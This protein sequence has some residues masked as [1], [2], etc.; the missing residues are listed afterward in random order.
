[1]PESEKT[2]EKLISHYR[3]KELKLN[4]DFPE[5]EMLDCRPFEYSKL[6]LSTDQ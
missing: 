1:M 4:N 2:Y 6:K 3:G 5:T